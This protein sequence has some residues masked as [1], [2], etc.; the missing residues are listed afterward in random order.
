MPREKKPVWSYFKEILS[1]TNKRAKCKNCGLE[2]VN[3]AARMEKHIE[4]DC[5]GATES[6]N[7][8]AGPSAPETL[9]Q[10]TLHMASSKSKQHDIDLQ[11]TRYFIATN[12]PFNAASNDHLKRLVEKLRPNTTIPDRRDIAGRLLDEVYDEEKDKVKLLVSEANCTL[13]LDGVRHC[14]MSQFWEFASTQMDLVTL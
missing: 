2:I 13:S 12:T 1:R 7:D 11:I 9:R 3:N 14:L 10:T 4:K 8:N 5:E 6:E